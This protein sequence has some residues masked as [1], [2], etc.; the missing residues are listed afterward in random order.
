MRSVEMALF[1][2]ERPKHATTLLVTIAKAPKFV[3]ASSPIAAHCK[4]FLLPLHSNV[5]CRVT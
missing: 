2:S 4:C 5:N 1:H 3:R